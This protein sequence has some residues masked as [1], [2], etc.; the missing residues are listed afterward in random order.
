LEEGEA[1]AKYMI[2][3]LLSLEGL[4]L[5]EKEGQVCYRYGKEAQELE[6]MDYLEFVAGSLS[7]RISP[8][9][10]TSSTTSSSCSSLISPRRLKS[11]IKSF[12]WPPR[13]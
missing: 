13:P 9:W 2:R 5:D 6:R 8:R 7:S 3:L 4:S 12:C 10:I 11:F 1:A